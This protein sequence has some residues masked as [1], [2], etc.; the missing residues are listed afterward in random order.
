MNL[1]LSPEVMILLPFF[2]ALDLIGLGLICFGLDDFGI[3]DTLGI[4]IGGGYVLFSG[5]KMPDSKKAGFKFIG[6]ISVELIP[7]IGA[8][9][10][11][12]LWFLNN[13]K[14][15]NQMEEQQKTENENQDEE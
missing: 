2:A 5:G 1:K 9:P 10:T 6:T 7:Y 12:T 14:E 13:L 3:T 11:W 8:F 4:T 15:K